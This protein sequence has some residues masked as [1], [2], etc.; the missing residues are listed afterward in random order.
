MKNGSFWLLLIL[1][2]IFIST[3]TS[4][5][6]QSFI[7]DLDDAVMNFSTVEFNDSSNTKEIYFNGSE[8]KIL[9]VNLPKNSTIINSSIRIEGS[10]K[11]IAAT[12]KEQVLDLK[13]GNINE[14]IPWDEILIGTA[15]SS[16]NI[17]LLN[18]SGFQ[19][20]NYSINTDVS[21][22][23]FG[24]L[25][26]QKG[27]EIVASSGSKIFL[28]NSTG[29]QIQNKSMNNIIYDIEVADVTS[30]EY[31][32]IAVAAGDNKVY[33]LSNSLSEIWNYSSSLPFRGVGIGNLNA[34]SGKEIAASSGSTIFILDSSGNL[35]NSKDIGYLINDID[36]LDIDDSGY[37]EIAVVTDNGTLYMIDNELNILWSYSP[38]AAIDN[39]KIGEVTTEYNG[40]EIVIGSYDDYVYVVSKDGDLVWKYKTENDVKG[41]GIGNLTSDP[42]NEVAA[43]TQIPA[44]YTLHI[45][46]FEYFPT[47]VTLD[48]SSDNDIEWSYGGKFR[49]S[50]N[51]T[52]NSEVQDFIN[53]CSP[54]SFG[55][56]QLPL[57]FSSDF[58]GILKINEINISYS[59]NITN[60]FYVSLAS[61]WSRND[62]IAANE[63]VGNQIKKINYLVN[64]SHD[65][66]IKYIAVSNSAT[67]CDFNGTRF[68]VIT[69]QG[70]KVCDISSKP[71]TI[72]SNQNLTYD[73]IW[74]NTMSS[75]IPILY[76]ETEGVAQYGFWKKNI[77]VWNTT[78][79]IFTNIILSTSLDENY[80]TGNS[81]LRVDW[82]NNGTLY[83]IT[84]AQTR[85]NCNS[86]PTYSE[87]SIE[88]Y[89]FFVCKQDTNNDGRVDF[90]AWK[91]PD[92]N[93]T[94][95]IYEVSG[96]ANNP[97]VINNVNISSDN[98][99]G[100]NFTVYVNVSDAEGNNI[101]VIPCINLTK[102][103][104]INDINTSQLT[105]QC[106]SEKNTTSNTIYGEELYFEIETNST[107]V[108]YNILT[109]LL[110]D[111][112][113]ETVYHDYSYYN[114]YYGPNVTKHLTAPIIV[115][116][117]ESHINRSQSILL[118][119]YI[120]DSI[121]NS[122]ATSAVCMFW[123]S[124]NQTSWD[125]GY[126]TSTNSSG[127]CNYLFTPNSS[128]EPG[129]RW[130]RVGVYNDNIYN[131][132][133]S[134][135][136]TIYL[137]GKMNVNFTQ[138]I[139]Q[140]NI[141][142]NQNRIISARI[143]DEYGQQIRLSGQQCSFII[144]QTQIG[145]NTTNSTGVCQISFQPSCSYQLGLY[146]FNVSLPSSSNTY[147]YLDQK[148]HLINLFIK[149]TINSSIL[150][151]LTTEIYHKGE[152][153][154][155]SSYI[156]DSCGV[157]EHQYT[158]TWIFNCT[159]QTY[160]PI[161]NSTIATNTT[162]NVQCNPG[163][164][165][166]SNR[167]TG[168]LYNQNTQTRNINIYG[169]SQVK[170][171]QPSNG[172]FNRTETNRI[173]NISCEVS[174]AN[175]TLVK[176]DPY[177]VDILYKYEGGNFVKL[178]SM[179]T[180]FPSGTVNYL[181]N[182]SSNQTVPEGLYTIMCNIT[183]QNL[184]AYRK[185]NASQKEDSKDIVII[186]KDTTPPKINSI[187]INSTL[188][189][190]NTSITANITDWYGVSHAWIDVYHPNGTNQTIY[191]T[192]STGDLKQTV[193]Y[194]NFTQMNFVGDYD[195]IL[196]ANDTSNYTSSN[197]T[198]F[199]VY[200]TIQLY[201]DTS[202]PVRYLFYRPGRNE[203]IHNFTN[204]AGQQNLTLHQRNYDLYA[205]IQDDASQMHEIIF[206]DLNSTETSKQQ[207]G[208]VSNITNPLNI[209]VIPL[210]ILNPPV[211]WRHEIA[212]IYIS[213]SFAYSNVT[214]S[215]DYSKK[216]G[217]IDYA[218][219]LVIY[220]CSNWTGQCSS[221]WQEVN[222]TVNS[223][224]Y[225]AFT[226]QNSTSAYYLFEA[227][228]CGNSICGTGESCVNCVADCGECSTGGTGMTQ[229]PVSS[230]AGGAGSSG[231]KESCGNGICDTTENPF[232]CPQ[233]C[234]GVF[235]VKTNLTQDYVNPGNK[236]SYS[237]WISNLM[238]QSIQANIL[239]NGPA[240]NL[241]SLRQK[242]VLVES[243]KEK[244]VVIDLN[245]PENIQVG[246][247][248]GE[249]VV[250]SGRSERLPITI[251]VTKDTSELQLSLK[252]ITKTLKPNET[253]AFEVG[254]YSLTQKKEI[255][256]E[257]TYAI[258]RFKQDDIIY[259]ET[260][261]VSIKTPH[262]IL[263]YI[264][265]PENITSGKYYVVVN[266]T[267]SDGKLSAIDTFDISSSIITAATLRYIII[268]IVSLLSI[269]IA[270]VAVRKYIQW[271]KSKLRYIFP[272]NFGLL[273]Q[274]DLHL[275]KVAE[276]NIKATFSSNDIT[277]H[278]IVAGSTGAGKSVSAS[279]FAEELL[280]KKIPVVVFDPTAQWTGFVKPC[281]DENV[282][283]YYKNHGLTIDNT[284]SY[285][286]NIYEMT[287]PKAK[288]D[289]KKYMNPGEITVFVL[290]KLK[291]GEYDEAVT[292]IIDSIFS[293]S[294]EESTQPRL[295]IVFDEVH[296]LL[297]K[298]GGKGGYVALER[299]CREFRKWG[300]GL[301]M[302]SQVLS[303]F[304]EAIKGN[305]L[306]EIQMH[307][308]SLNDLQRIEKKYGLEYARRVAKEEVGIG[309][310][311]NPK[312]NKGMPWFISFRPPLHMPHKIT[313][314]EMQMY[315]E[316]NSRIEK[317]EQEI[318]KLASTGKD[319]FD[320]RIEL[321]LAK[322]KLK[323]GMFRVAEIYI[324]SLNKKLGLSK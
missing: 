234:T 275:G 139:Y 135:N 316:Y 154:N 265:L 105:W 323:K 85:T 173:I 117:N 260:E 130:W 248:T 245:V 319:V 283:K 181:W 259:T 83:D 84:P 281:K 94:F 38:G 206:N 33:L 310:I 95:T 141:T 151:P 213:S 1:I 199:E 102:T 231:Y 10:M 82:F 302:A 26:S 153:M 244:E 293:Q 30:D 53:S 134:S 13:V 167:I 129:L 250:S 223:T 304:K 106:F 274:G 74:D 109:F 133:L 257:I 236:K 277:T 148:Q 99:W 140:S 193:W 165:I 286:G 150:S 27:K 227:E 174:D 297:E 175:N 64:P 8:T 232:T 156:L 273:P 120:N 224:S 287:D 164:L 91:Q 176:L 178:A 16:H 72:F 249:I 262:Q 214:V 203:I 149:D 280:E 15:G 40:N 81:K 170:L 294:W 200:D 229:Q 201:A 65:F 313:D 61:E 41:V 101:S 103:F 172:T 137:Y 146:E 324:E 115:Q 307:T 267:Y 32:E 152:E 290:N 63:S 29:S 162:W 144:N 219:A 237:L 59:Y 4:V 52:A 119:A 73:F 298:Y 143:F 69:L 256:A 9:W 194:S 254:F 315:K 122:P 142:R 124:K 168:E 230:A 39:V 25:S 190:G 305:V 24:N 160:P 159:S 93:R 104:D 107:W 299:A 255:E 191:L 79:Q 35:I 18:A 303:D 192:N 86:N 138:S 169:W 92:T 145:T 88:N 54:D 50:A 188:K 210:I 45:L 208:S 180:I 295:I 113:N 60:I 66:Q 207:F 68:N 179:N 90:F 2:V 202:Y 209:S 128:Y 243:S 48:I 14:D 296:R 110:S 212:G 182:I 31:E 252:T 272:V 3:V 57:N 284:K 155:L 239:I 215:F 108:G 220:K 216:I 320:L 97:P 312:Y 121:D 22:V 51:I 112:E 269:I 292:N 77:T 126:Q 186:E 78:T 204:P 56:C 278:I 282:L 158:S 317:L 228:I 166:L 222:T 127:Y 67:V 19:I 195:I 225:K 321:K 218:P 58:D 116:G 87:I 62:S 136:Q 96:S 177:S 196:Y 111:F 318:E 314:Q 198:W 322:D 123:I 132:S 185:Y 189:G 5:N 205:E 36:V 71:K 264:H 217:E 46:N 251:F 288:I 28:F 23:N 289:F 300:I 49:S 11:P 240:S 261:Q 285:P 70:S 75:S 44:V 184:D 291:P 17:R 187:K 100:R 6:Q 161:Y 238:S 311:Q 47:N 271:K 43:G 42:G 247:Y 276:T 98:F 12:I 34:I 183:D 55:Y 20:W 258:Q 279:I 242:S 163:I 157:P 37:D 301:I 125:L 76:N 226:L 235:S 131:D 253:L 118:S 308:K 309:M 246:T 80:I 147:Y 270:F 221:G 266:A 197:S 211:P 268:G 306:T 233:D 114:V 89:T 21:S 7:F 263:K 241:L 171:L